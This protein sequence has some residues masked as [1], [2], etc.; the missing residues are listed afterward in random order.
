[1]AGEITD[2]GK[3]QRLAPSPMSAEE[4]ANVDPRIRLY[5][6]FSARVEDERLLDTLR[7]MVEQAKEE[8]WTP[9]EFTN[10]VK[11]AISGI[12]DPT[13]E[14]RE[15]LNNLD[16]ETRKKYEA[17]VR[18]IDS[19]ARI[20]LIYR[21]QLAIAAGL[22]QFQAGMTP[23]QLAMNPAWRFKRQD[24]AKEEYK[25][26]DHVSHEDEVR[27]KTD[28]AYWLDRNRK[29]IGGFELPH[30]PFGY[31]SWMR[32]VPVSRKEAEALGLLKPGERL[33][34]TDEEKR[35]YGISGDG[36]IPDPAST[37]DP[38]RSVKGMTDE[39]KRK[40]K[41]DTEAAGGTVKVDDDGNRMTPEYPAAPSKPKPHAP[42]PYP[43]PA[44][45]DG[46]PDGMDDDDL[47]IWMLVKLA[48]KPRRAQYKTEKEYKEALRKWRGNLL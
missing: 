21:T 13:G 27:L 15:E 20:E 45:P 18:N 14:H 41:E 1:M 2:L 25:R 31:N 8:G 37:V 36:S 7:R 16:D 29:E 5:S 32:L 48:R 46:V 43:A 23:L 4:W 34:L 11:E 39:G 30:A 9:T 12:I 28:F 44:R 10:A 42:A 26:K 40:V 35:L 19:R 38:S 3:L 47:L 33:E 22:A 17:D 6:F 24:G